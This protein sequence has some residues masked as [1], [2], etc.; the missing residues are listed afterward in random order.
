MKR[1][2]LRVW[3]PRTI[4]VGLLALVL[5]L[6]GCADGEVRVPKAAVAQSTDLPVTVIPLTTENVWEFS[7]DP[8]TAQPTALPEVRSGEYRV[9][10]GD[11]VSVFVFDQPEMSLPVGANGTSMGFL[12]QSD[13]TFSFPF[14]D[15]VTAAGRTTREIQRDMVERLATFI[16]SPQVDVRVMAFNSQRVVVGGEVEEPST[17]SITTWPLTLLEAVNAA[18]GIKETADASRIIVRRRGVNYS[19]DLESFL[20]AS[21]DRNNPILVGGDVVSVPRRR[22]AEAYILGEVSEPAT[23]DLAKEAVNLTQAIARQGGLEEAR[24][25]ARGVFVFRADGAGA[26]VYQLDLSSPVGLTLG[27]RFDLA[28]D[29]VVYVTRSPLQRWNDT[30]SRI[31]PSVSAVRTIGRE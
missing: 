17:Q 21:M 10:A 26:T 9:G 25:D 18:G 19:V 3:H 15:N 4:H 12:V 14:L 29:D 20:E 1:S 27:S 28:P 22:I 7:A 5:P 2:K 23:I 30:I 24:A 11:V 16:P 31:L 8:G 13:G 6:F